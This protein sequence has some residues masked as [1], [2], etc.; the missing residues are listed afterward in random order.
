MRT[1]KQKDRDIPKIQLWFTESC[2]HLHVKRVDKP[3]ARLRLALLGSPV[4]HGDCTAF[5]SEMLLQR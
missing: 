5:L 4:A 3:G 1:H 2:F